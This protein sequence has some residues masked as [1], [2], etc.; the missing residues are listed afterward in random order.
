MSPTKQMGLWIIQLLFPV[1]CVAIYVL[2]QIVLVLRTLDDR[3][4]LGDIAFGCLAFVA[5]CV[6]MFAFSNEICIG[7]KH[8]IDGTFFGVLC[9]LF[10]VMMVYKYWDSI[11]K[12]DLEFSVGSKQSVWEIKD[13][14]L[15][16]GDA[17]MGNG[18]YSTHES[19]P[20]SNTSGKLAPGGGGMAK[21]GLGYP[22]SGPYGAG[23]PY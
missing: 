8:Y 15:G 22:P 19:Y 13:P 17:D 9:L 7:V 3:W 12:E 1:I 21:S 5:A 6:L 20:R 10:A 11:T 23:S 4:P 2:S 16:P 18:S 14:L